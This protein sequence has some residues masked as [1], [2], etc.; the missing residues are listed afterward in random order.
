MKTQIDFYD[1]RFLMFV[2]DEM[3]YEY[4]KKYDDVIRLTLGKSELP[5]CDAILRAM[6]NAVTDFNKSALVFPAGLPQLREK[7]AQQYKKRYKV[8]LNP[9]NVV[10][11]TGTSAIFRNLYHLL[12]GQGDEILIPL[13]YY[14][15]YKFCALLVGATIKYYKVDKETL[16]LDLDSFKENFTEK[17]KLV[18]INSPGNPLGNIV[19]EDELWAID[20]I[21][22]GRAHIISDEIY[23]NTCFDSEYCTSAGELHNTK[24]TF[25][26]TNSFSKAYRMYSRRVGYCIVP[27]ELVEPMTVVQHHTLLTTDP[28]PQFGAIEAI[29]HPEEVDYLVNLYR[30]R[31]DYTIEKFECVPAV[32]AI[33]AQGSF[34]LTLDSTAFMAKNGISNCLELAQIIMEQTHVATVPGSDFGI[35]GTLR[36]SYSAKKYEKGIDRLAEFFISYNGHS[37]NGKT[38]MPQ[39]LAEAVLMPI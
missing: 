39:N 12:A 2:M 9:N 16:T 11:S 3:A 10:V 32:R 35:P 23:D 36:L 33:P 1:N 19:T 21:V 22:D 4:E 24:S 20:S 8:D 27:E 14:S 18:V 26:V 38:K 37:E 7:I 25:I 29:D 31:R 28:V 6:K 17:T 13:P 34:Y 15:L 5:V 30:S